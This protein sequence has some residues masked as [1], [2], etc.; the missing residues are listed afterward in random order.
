[1]APIRLVQLEGFLPGNGPHCVAVPDEARQF[2][3]LGWDHSV[4]GFH[5]QSIKQSDCGM[6]RGA[7]PARYCPPSLSATLRAWA[8]KPSASANATAAGPI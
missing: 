6:K 1:M 8:C 4:R 2:R 7:K 3:I 5:R